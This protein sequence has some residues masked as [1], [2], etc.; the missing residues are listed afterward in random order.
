MLEEEVEMR[1]GKE[2]EG[3]GR[4][5]ARALRGI[6]G[7]A[8]GGRRPNPE[9]VY[10]GKGRRKPAEGGVWAGAGGEER[11]EGKGGMGLLGGRGL[12]RGWLGSHVVFCQGPQ[13]ALPLF[14][15]PQNSSN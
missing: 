9:G 15:H 1:R 3:I 12:L 4:L 6:S 13:D 14:H 5:R 8:V 7:A 2:K 11:R 10:E